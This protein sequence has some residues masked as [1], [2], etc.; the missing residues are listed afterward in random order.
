MF[1]SARI[2]LTLWYLLI[3]VII[4]LLFSFV[5]YYQIDREL[6]RNF[7]RSRD[8]YNSRQEFINLPPPPFSDPSELEDSEDR[9][10]WNLL[11]LNL[12]ILIISGTA[13][14]FLAGRTLKPIKEMVDEQNRF[15]TDAS[16]ELRTPLTS[17]KISIEVNLR[18]QDLN[19]KQAKS[20]LNSNL[21]EVNSM[22]VLSDELL[23]LSQPNAK[24][25][26][27]QS[28]RLELKK[29][30]KAAISKVEVSSNKKN[31]KI[32][33]QIKDLYILG[34]QD[35]LIALIVIFLDNAIK[36]SSNKSPVTIKA[37]R[38]DGQVKVS[39]IDQGIGIDKDQLSKIFDRFYRTDQSRSKDSQ[40]GFGLGLAIAK[41][42]ANSMNGAIDVKSQLGL[43]TTFTL[44]FP[45]A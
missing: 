28:E 38:T 22:Q 27:D 23:T 1:Y 19:L 9:L 12:G 42:M 20:L 43:G 25:R 5:I 2:K 11:Y 33:T 3:I 36:Y 31:I 8:F 34:N 26:T 13:G 35:S 15:I 39:I 10:K 17:M 18:D 45:A 30:I 32:K 41:K 29:I 24:L 40:N 4:S 16:H 44:T 14:Y 7:R 6:N 37:D 21:E